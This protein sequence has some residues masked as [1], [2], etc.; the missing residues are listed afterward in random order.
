MG[1]RL[2]RLPIDPL[3]FEQGGR[4]KIARSGQSVTL[5]AFLYRSDAFNE[6][7]NDKRNPLPP[8]DWVAQRDVVAGFD[9]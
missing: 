2:R 8:A 7:V 4:L 9:A 1:L 3:R 6:A 5:G